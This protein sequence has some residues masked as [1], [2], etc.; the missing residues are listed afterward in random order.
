V[1]A[2]RRQRHSR[3]H[4]DDV[5]LVALDPTL[6]FG[7]R[8]FADGNGVVVFARCHQGSLQAGVEH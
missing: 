8:P 1:L 3:V 6:D 4:L 7:L 5:G 2:I